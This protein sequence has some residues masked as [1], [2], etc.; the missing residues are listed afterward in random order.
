MSTT[1]KHVY[2]NQMQLN[3]HLLATF[4]KFSSHRSQ[5]NESEKTSENKQCGTQPFKNRLQACS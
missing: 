5:E 1:V 4:N 3:T 2:M